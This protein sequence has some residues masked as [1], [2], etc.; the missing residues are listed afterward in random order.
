MTTLVPARSWTCIQ[1]ICDQ[2]TNA[3]FKHETR[4]HDDAPAIER[5]VLYANICSLSVDHVVGI[6]TIV[7]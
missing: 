1:E 7:G 3:N 4:M 6:Y 2:A 5:A